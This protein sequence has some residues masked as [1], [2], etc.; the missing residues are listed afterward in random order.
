MK[1]QYHNPIH[2]TFGPDA[3]ER[4]PELCQGKKVLLVYGGGSIK[5]NGVYERITALLDGADI[6]YLDY[7]NQVKATWQGVMDGITLARRDGVDA[8]RGGRG[9]GGAGLRQAAGIDRAG[10]S[11]AVAGLPRSLPHQGICGKIPGKRGLRRVQPRRNVRYHRRLLRMSGRIQKR[12]PRGAAAFHFPP[13]ASTFD[14]M[15]MN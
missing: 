2:F 12:L 14:L 11:F 15:L 4:L 9:S 5:R 3:L 1:F 6:P 10:R 13:S 7:G 8:R